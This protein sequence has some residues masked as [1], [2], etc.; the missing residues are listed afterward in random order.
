[1]T[2]ELRALLQADLDAERPPP[3]GDIV[4]AAMRAGRRKRRKRRLRLGA[5]LAGVLLLAALLSDVLIPARDY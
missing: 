3:I 4:G 2:D 1:M 5:A